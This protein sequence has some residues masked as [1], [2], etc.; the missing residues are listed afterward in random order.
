MD[1]SVP[2]RKSSVLRRA[3]EEVVRVQ[4]VGL[5]GKGELG[6]VSFTCALFVSHDGT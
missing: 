5:R 4:D 6:P 2:P 1:I 3:F